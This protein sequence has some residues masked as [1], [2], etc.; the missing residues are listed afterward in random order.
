MD[1]PQLEITPEAWKKL[2][3]G[4]GQLSTACRTLSKVCGLF[5]VSGNLI[6]QT[7]PKIPQTVP[8]SN[9]E[10]KE[11]DEPC[12]V[13]AYKKRYEKRFC[14]SAEF[15][16][17]SWW[18]V[19]FLDDVLK[20]AFG[21]DVRRD[22]MK[23][24]WLWGAEDCTWRKISQRQFELLFREA[25]GF[26]VDCQQWVGSS[27]TRIAF[28]DHAGVAITPHQWAKRHNVLDADLKL[29]R[30]VAY[31]RGVHDELPSLRGLLKSKNK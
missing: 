6:P 1:V 24:T 26:V 4:L 16:M 10:K 14:R 8:K 11:A 19:K 28:Q 2:E 21:M 13:A 25:L 3:K 12:P 9:E 20:Y 7:V 5:S 23:T 17:S 30:F 18:N 29:E 15:L 22:R 31:T 27:D